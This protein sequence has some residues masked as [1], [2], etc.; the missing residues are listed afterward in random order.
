MSI[1]AIFLTVILLQVAGVSFALQIFF[2]IL[3]AKLQDE[4]IK[5]LQDGTITGHIFVS[6]K[7][8]ASS[9][10]IQFGSRFCRSLVLLFYTRI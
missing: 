6:S 1:R 10:M 9:T 3:V 8:D 4:T 7:V 5:K 2:N